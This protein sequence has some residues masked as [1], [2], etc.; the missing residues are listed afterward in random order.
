MVVASV[1]GQKLRLEGALHIEMVKEKGR[2][3]LAF[4]KIK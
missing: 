4:S 2:V 1:F 3:K